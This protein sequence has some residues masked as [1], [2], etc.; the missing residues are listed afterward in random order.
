MVGD[1]S[2]HYING[3]IE[4]KI[5]VAVYTAQE[6]YSWQNGTAISIQ[7]LKE[8]KGCIGKFP[9]PDEESF[10][11]GGVFLSDESVVFYRYHIAKKIDFRGRDALYCV[12]GVIPKDEAARVDP[13]ALFSL[14][15][16]ADV[17]KPFPT[18]SDIS[19][20][21]SEN[22]P[23]WLKGL[24]GV[25]LDVRISG[26][27]DDMKF[28]VK[29]EPVKVPEPVKQEKPAVIPKKET[30]V[31][32][33]T[34]PDKVEPKVD[35]IAPTPKIDPSLLKVSPAFSENAKSKEKAKR[36]VWYKNPRMIIIG[37]VALLTVSALVAL[38]IYL[39]YKVCGS[40]SDESSGE[41]EDRNSRIVEAK[42]VSTEQEQ[43]IMPMR[44]NNPDIRSS[45]K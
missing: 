14:P 34:R 9:T 8:Y 13:K 39:T 27:L 41:L 12:L 30:P 24:E 18:Q 25:I 26:S 43:A 21:F 44:E 31:V 17:M 29:K 45:S 42:E 35:L 20:A 32:I 37:A 22:T 10:P 11:F 3:V 16:F 5:D 6:G 38:G 33:E 23:E 1:E 4:M 19:T 2:K 7:K 40:K 36:K 28:A 15:E